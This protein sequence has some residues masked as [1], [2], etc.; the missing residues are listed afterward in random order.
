MAWRNTPL[1]DAMRDLALS[2]AYVPRGTRLWTFGSKALAHD[3]GWTAA[4]GGT[5]R[6]GRG[7][8]ELQPAGMEITLVSPGR[9]VLRRGEVALLVL[10]A[11]APQD[12][13][14][15][16]LEVRGENGTWMP[17]GF[18]KRDALKEDPAGLLLPIAWPK[19]LD[20]AEQVRVTIG[21]ARETKSLTLRHVALYRAP[22]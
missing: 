14:S 18:A 12:I 11:D 5:V 17:A 22:R 1:E 19:P 6:P 7:N 8:L 20:V 15:V 10:G 21:L 13:A 4:S 9:L 16:R 3:D 2:H